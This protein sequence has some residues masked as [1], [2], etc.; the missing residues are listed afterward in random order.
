M[1]VGGGRVKCKGTVM[2]VG[3]LAPNPEAVPCPDL[4]DSDGLDTNGSRRDAG[5]HATP[6][7][8]SAAE[9]NQ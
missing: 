4:R 1:T 5:W 7:R 2:V 9:A 6:H 3:S 8:I